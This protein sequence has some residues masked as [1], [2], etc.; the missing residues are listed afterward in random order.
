M[1]IIELVATRR[2]ESK[3]CKGNMVSISIWFQLSHCEW[4]KASTEKGHNWTIEWNASISSYQMLENSI[5]NKIG[6]W[7]EMLHYALWFNYFVDLFKREMMQTNDFIA[8]SFGHKFILFNWFWHEFIFFSLLQI[9]YLITYMDV[10]AQMD[11]LELAN[12]VDADRLDVSMVDSGNKTS[13]F[14]RLQGSAEIKYKEKAKLG[15]KSTK[16]V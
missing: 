15:K 9:V 1:S 2:R 12:E 8:I 13:L 6:G 16:D 3:W 5:T 7:F 14:L 4:S 11:I 10:S